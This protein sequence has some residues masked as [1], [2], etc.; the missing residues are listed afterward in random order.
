MVAAAGASMAACYYR[1][2]G[3]WMLNS[4]I[5]RKQK[6]LQLGGKKIVCHKLCKSGKKFCNFLFSTLLNELVV[7]VNYNRLLGIGWSSSI[8]RA[9]KTELKKSS[10][11]LAWFGLPV[12]DT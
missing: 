7:V 1:A 10:A 11:I 3:I 2:H 5:F 4:C 9:R 6:L 12:L 8:F